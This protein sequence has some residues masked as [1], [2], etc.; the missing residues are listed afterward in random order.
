[1][2]I[3]R[4][5]IAL[6]TDPIF[7]RTFYVDQNSSAAHDQN[8][9]TFL[10]PWKT[11]E[12]ANHVL[13]AGDTVY[14][15]QGIYH[16]YFAPEN[17]GTDSY[18]IV[19]MNYGTDTVTVS[20]T[21]Y[22]VNLNGRSHIIV[23]GI[24]FR[25]VDRFL[26]L[27]NGAND[28][29]IEYCIF[30]QGQDIDWSGARIYNNSSF[31]WIHHC[32]FS[33][34]GYYNADDIGAIL[35][36]GSEES[37][38]DF[39]N[40]NLL[41]DNIFFHGGHHILGVFSMYN[42]I[43][44]NYFHNEPWSMGNAESDRGAVLYGNRN[45][46]FS[47]Y[48]ENSGFNLFECNR[49]AYS[50]DPPDNIGA[51]GMALTTSHNI[52]RFNL[53]YFNDR[54][55][56]SMSLTKYYYSDIVSNKLYHNTY[57][58]NGINTQ[59]PDDHMNSAIG[60]G[61]YSGTHIIQHNAIKNNLLFKHRVPYGTYR[62]NLLDQIF[63]GNWLGDEQGDPKFV[64]AA[65][66]LGDPMDTYYPDLRLQLGSPCIDSGTFLTTIVSADGSGRSFQVEDAGYFM[67]GWGIVQG[68]SIQLYGSDQ[69]A[70]I[71]HVD[72]QSNLL[73]IDRMMTWTRNQGVCLVY[74]SSAPD[75]GAYEQ[76]K[77]LNPPPPP[78]LRFIHEILD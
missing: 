46:Y 27:Q 72:Y 55:G 36:I 1:M 69:W 65:I 40:F 24:Q 61:L 31:N 47:G 35:D 52:V 68:D 58:C 14:I 59:D 73:T 12:K 6:H 11:I 19:Y 34:Y 26:W 30:D 77:E 4:S 76:G 8:N 16:S 17:S 70:I 44:R 56:T 78:K 45:V 39:S 20:N 32:Q 37:K 43:R 3:L 57:F 53:F 23:R 33:N 63:T 5:I 50:S 54:A 60:F 21:A 66:A 9:G 25:Y 41:E 75:I 7:A 10:S 48:P 18:P 49:V 71:S 13:T 38:T 67:D 62:V 28:N 15:R 74:I 2:I 51:S 42:V 64:K 29:R 22:G